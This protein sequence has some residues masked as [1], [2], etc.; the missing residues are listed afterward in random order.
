MP[1]LLAVITGSCLW[2]WSF[3]LSAADQKTDI[4][5]PYNKWVE[6]AVVLCSCEKAIQRNAKLLTGANSPTAAWSFWYSSVLWFCARFPVRQHE[7][8]WHK[9]GGA[10]SNSACFLTSCIQAFG[11]QLLWNT[12]DLKAWKGNKIE[13]LSLV[14]NLQIMFIHRYCDKEGADESQWLAVCSVVQPLLWWET[15]I[16]HLFKL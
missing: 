10:G 4:K 12:F 11:I 13:S 6:S 8:A 9:I 2:Q 15:I 5:S 1:S 14:Y 16:F 3:D 7:V